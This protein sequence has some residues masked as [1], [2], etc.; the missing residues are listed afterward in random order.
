MNGHWHQ[1]LDVHE[2]IAEIPE[3]HL[4]DLRTKKSADALRRH[5]VADEH[6]DFQ[7]DESNDV[8]AGI[9]AAA[10]CVPYGANGTAEDV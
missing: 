10:S 7:P 3:K 5:D 1:A 2:R 8:T 6:R 9:Q 4:E